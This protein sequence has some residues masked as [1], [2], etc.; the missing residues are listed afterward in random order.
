M[1]REGFRNRLKQYKQAREEN[2]GLKYWEWKDIPKYDEGTSGIMQPFVTDGNNWRKRPTQEQL[3]AFYS[4][5]VKRQVKLA[6]QTGQ[7]VTYTNPKY[8][9]DEVVVTA[10]DLKKEQQR[11]QEYNNL[12]DLGITATGF[13][14]GLGEV[15]DAVDVINQ[16]R[17]GNY[18]DA[19]LSALAAIIPGVPAS[20]I[21]RGGNDITRRYLKYVGQN[22]DKSFAGMK[23]NQDKL[24]PLQ[25]QQLQI[26][27]DNGVDPHYITS[28]NLDK[29]LQIREKTLFDTA[30]SNW[31]YHKPKWD[32]D[33]EIME[34]QLFDLNNAKS[35]T[36]ERA[37]YDVS[38]ESP[39]DAAINNAYMTL[40]DTGDH[41]DIGMVKKTN[42]Y[43]RGTYEHLLNAATNVAKFRKRKG[44]L[45]GRD[46]MSPDITKHLWTKYNDKELFSKNGGYHLYGAYQ[47]GDIM[48]IKSPTYRVPETKSILFNPNVLSDDGKMIIDWNSEDVSFAEGGEVTGPPTQ[49]KMFKKKSTIF[50]DITTDPTFYE[51]VKEK[52][53]RARYERAA[54]HTGSGD[55]ANVISYMWDSNDENIPYY[56]GSYIRGFDSEKDYEGET[57]AYQGNTT[58][59]QLTT[60]RTPNINRDLVKNFIYGEDKG[61]KKSNKKP[62]IVNG[63]IYPDRQYYGNIAPI[64]TIYL[65][66]SMQ[67]TID[68]LIAEKSIYS[69][70]HNSGY[71]PSFYQQD[72]MKNYT[73]DNVAQHS[74]VFHKNKRNQ[75]STELFDLWDF[76]GDYKYGADWIAHAFQKNLESDQFFP[77]AGPFVLRQEIPIKFVKDNVLD[78][79]RRSGKSFLQ[80][81]NDTS[82]KAS[83]R[84]KKFVKNWEY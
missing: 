58:V 66:K 51:Y 67:P 27:L 29:A 7:T 79:T 30:P 54:H 20:I 74:G 84:L 44:V 8:T 82:N 49:K 9:L 38:Y 34:D 75:Y 19:G 28:K 77:N 3:D 17:Q 25:K 64:D 39:K 24:T 26:L 16:L 5:N 71:T 53:G 62:L 22:P 78:E 43:A 63:E 18:S 73:Y 61:F 40:T 80:N 48:N 69:M 1:D 15:A 56:T 35:V 10:N 72:R 47:P 52:S 33:L 6:E 37:L 50:E 23:I 31:I 11:R 14:P 36:P 76:M 21:R 4:G 42:Q 2:P 70:N 55:L 59:G 57:T 13:V 12:L 32:E 68:S 81:L 41:M 65:P 60:D 45:S 46:L 83:I